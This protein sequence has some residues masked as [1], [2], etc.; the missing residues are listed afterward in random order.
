M[1]SLLRS[2]CKTIATAASYSFLKLFTLSKISGTRVSH[3][4]VAHIMTPVLAAHTSTI[5]LLSLTALRTLAHLM[6]H[7][8]AGLLA[9]CYHMPS[10]IGAYY[11]KSMLSDS[12][13]LR[14]ACVIAPLVCMALFMSTT[15]GSQA[16]PYSLYWLIPALIPLIPHKSIFLIALGSTFLTHAVGSVFFILTTPMTAAFW[17]TLMPI[18]AFE[19]CMVAAGITGLYY[20]V[21]LIQYMRKRIF[22]TLAH[23]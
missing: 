18:V 5:E 14:R 3:F 13:N 10:L 7:P 11:F 21:T 15:V 19:R 16:W 8:T 6:V 12:H 22:T 23:A 9:L 2:S 20:T 17:L 1:N 4:S